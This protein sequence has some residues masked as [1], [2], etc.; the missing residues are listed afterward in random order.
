VLNSLS[1]RLV[2]QETLRVTD[3]PI[4]LFDPDQLTDQELARL[5]NLRGLVAAGIEPYPARVQRTHTIAAARA[6]HA[7]ETLDE[8]K[9]E[10]KDGNAG[11]V[12]SVVGRLKRIRIMGKVSFADLE[13]G[14]G[15]IQVLLRRDSL[16]DGWYDE[17]WKKLIDLGDFIGAT[18]PLVVTRTGEL[19]VEA[20]GVQFL[21]KTL[22]PM[23]D[24]WHG[25]RDRETRYRRR[26]VDLIAN[27]EVRE[28]FRTRAAIVR[29]LRDYL[30]GEG[31]L[32]VETPILQPIYGGA[33][34][35]PFITHHNQLHQDLY[36]RIS[37]ELYLKRLI[38]GGYER[39]Y[40]IGRD[41]RNEGVSFKHNPEFTQLEFY[42]AYTDYQ[43]VMRRTEEMIAH[44]ARAVTGGTT[45]RFRGQ[46][47]DLTPPWRRIPLREAILEAADIDYE[48]FPDAASLAQAMRTIGHDPE[49]GSSWGKLV[50]SLTGRHVE[51]TLIQ[52]TFLIDYP[53]DVSPLAKGSPDNPR[54]VERFE[55]FMGGLELCNAFSELNDPIDQL[56]R[57]MD[58]NYRASQG[59]EEA[60]PIDK[61]YIEALSFGLP[62]TGGFGMGVDR[63]TMLFTDKDTIREVILFPHLRSIKEDEAGGDDAAGEAAQPR[64]AETGS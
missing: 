37:F 48:E 63:L 23:P 8:T 32:E 56:Q 43:G 51:P 33:A 4:D 29:A 61:D 36:L 14:T 31:F 44:V 2:C 34:A 46:T 16:P 25:V 11:P 54:Q 47:I 42:E 22:K 9:D 53:R 7:S 58:E 27:P 21:S 17:V 13:D 24:K 39:V 6:L 10:A 1:D 20:T 45:I 12:V 18:G 60:H 38:V 5:Q 15:Q 30:D 35:L 40:E 28:L 55:G 41:F 62:P 57:F 19:S 64:E 50:D 52:P 3:L 59:D 49:P 26:Y